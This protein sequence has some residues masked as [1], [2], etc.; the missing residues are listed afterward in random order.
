MNEV[1]YIVNKISILIF[2]EVVLTGKELVTKFLYSE[3]T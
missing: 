2:E 3:V 1:I